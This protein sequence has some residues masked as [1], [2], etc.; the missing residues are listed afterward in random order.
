MQDNLGSYISYKV[1]TQS[2]IRNLFPDPEGIIIIITIAIVIIIISYYSL[3][4]VLRRY[5]DFKWLYDELCRTSG[6]IIFL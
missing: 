5:R 1:I 4:S 6:N 3:V 2:N